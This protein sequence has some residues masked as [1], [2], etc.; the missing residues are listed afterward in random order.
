MIMSTEIQK[1]SNRHWS[2]KE[3]A[4]ALRLKGLSYNEIRK[5]IPASKSSISLWCR[6]VKLT[7]RQIKRLGERRDH[8]LKG[9]RAI[10]QMFW[11]KRQEAFC[12]GIQKH[13]KNKNDTQFIAGLMLYWAEGTKAHSATITN[14]DY[15]VIKFMTR[16]FK[17]YFK[18]SSDELSI[19]L[20][21]HSGQD[22]QKMKQYWSQV[23]GAPIENFI[24]SFIKPE[25][26]GY[27]KNVLYNGT[28]KVRI[29]KS[30]SLYILYE[31]LGSIAG[32]LKKTLNEKSICEQWI[33]KLPYAT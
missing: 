7:K 33:A 14:S 4:Q 15:R 26:S 10:Q 9:I 3:K 6:D 24:K 16:W 11:D 32:F 29:K 22:E 13:L 31:I 23:T 12:R 30:G 8:S 2:L 27:R 28:A 25:G 5:K 17:E 1:H 19:H 18:V 20:H 21:L